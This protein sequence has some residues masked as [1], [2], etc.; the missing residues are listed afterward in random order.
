MKNQIFNLVEISIL[1][2]HGYRGEVISEK[3]SQSQADG[4]RRLMGLQLIEQLEE[5]GAR[6]T[7][8]GKGMVLLSAM[9]NLPIPVVSWSMP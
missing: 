7:V 8:T 6:F 1:V 5:G 9:Q 4:Y 2:H 3:A